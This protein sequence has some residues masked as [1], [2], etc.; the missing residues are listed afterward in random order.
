MAGEFSQPFFAQRHL[1]S[2][3]KAG[4]CMSRAGKDNC[5]PPNI[6][7]NLAIVLSPSIFRMMEALLLVSFYL[8]PLET[9][10]STL[11]T[12][13]QL[14]S[15]SS[16]T[17]LGDFSATNIVSRG[18]DKVGRSRRSDGSDSGGGSGSDWD[19]D[20]SMGEE[21]EEETEMFFMWI[22]LQ[23]PAGYGKK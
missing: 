21:E 2:A 15:S 19:S 10:C 18:L 11:V 14:S 13:T 6:L 16:Q 5:S 3:N 12:Q 22:E 17:L 7:P 9:T 20:L 1:S 4:S 8:F 23:P